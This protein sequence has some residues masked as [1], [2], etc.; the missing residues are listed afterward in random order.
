MNW[1]D[2]REQVQPKKVNV[3][4]RRGY[5]DPVTIPVVPPSYVEWITVDTLVPEPAIPRTLIGKD[6]VKLPNP[7]DVEYRQELAKVTVER[8]F[9]RL[10]MAL[11][12]GGTEIPGAGVLEKVETLKQ[13]FDSG[14][15]NALMMWLYEAAMGAKAEVEN[16][17]NSFRPG[18]GAVSASVAPLPLNPVAVHS[19][20]GNG[21][22]HDAGDGTAFQAQEKE[23]ARPVAADAHR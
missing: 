18:N 13:D 2:L 12:K 11:E 20:A 16:L 15:A 8:S 10:L 6:G 23:A 7:H 17:A 9:R 4:I 3:V 21:S 1:N 14:I 22:A 5:G 19:T